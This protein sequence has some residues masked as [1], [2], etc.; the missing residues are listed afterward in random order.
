MLAEG[1]RERDEAA[2]GSHDCCFFVTQKRVYEP[3]TACIVWCAL[4]EKIGDVFM[5]LLIHTVNPEN[6]H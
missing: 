2:S 3:N 5:I 4:Y 1:G 6:L